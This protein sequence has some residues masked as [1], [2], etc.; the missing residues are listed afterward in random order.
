MKFVEGHAA[1]V[2]EKPVKTLV[3]ADL[4][5]GFEEEYRS[6]GVKI[7]LQSPKIVEE[8]RNLAAEQAAERLLVVGD[9]KHNVRGPSRLEYELLPK[10]LK[11]LKKV[12]DEIVVVPGNHDGKVAQLL[13]GLASVTPMKGFVVEEEKTGFTHGHVRP[14]RKVLLM[15]FIVTGHLHP[16]LKV[17][18]G[19]SSAR[20]GIWLRIRGNR[21]KAAEMLYGKDVEIFSGETTLL[22]MPSFN[23]MMQGRSVTEISESGL[24]R[25]PLLK[26]KAFDLTTAEVI[27]LDGAYI[28][29]LRELRDVLG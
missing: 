10:L 15:D 29:T 11:P 1:M 23:K 27:G 26:T 2:I 18:S 24:I 7:P 14:D 21:R 16:V 13:A 5:L 20:I 6:K 17:G 3:V 4:H 19:M 12:V 25:G 8:L 22:I 9:L 28:G